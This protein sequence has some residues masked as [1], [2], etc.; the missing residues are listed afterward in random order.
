VTKEWPFGCQQ[1]SNLGSTVELQYSHS[2]IS[3]MYTYSRWE[4]HIGVSELLKELVVRYLWP[5]PLDSHQTA[6]EVGG[7]AIGVVVG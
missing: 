4:K 1:F 3:S 7:R 6:K 5:D 2:L